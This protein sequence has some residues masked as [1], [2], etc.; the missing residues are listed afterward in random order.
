MALLFLTFWLLQGYELLS[1]ADHADSL[2]QSCEEEASFIQLD[3][4]DT[5]TRESAWLL[6]KPGESCTETCIF[7]SKCNVAKLKNTRG[8]DLLQ[9]A[10]D[11]GLQPSAQSPLTDRRSVS[12]PEFLRT[13]PYAGTVFQADPNFPVQSCEAKTANYERFCY[14][15]KKPKN[16]C[17]KKEQRR[18]KKNR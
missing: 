16:C 10:R 11:L 17:T 15:V 3:K 4:A 13:G 7:G 6:G 9:V 2:N 12:S 8:K 14:C 18:C 5:D 1:S